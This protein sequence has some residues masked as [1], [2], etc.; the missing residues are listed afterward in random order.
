MSQPDAVSRAL[1]ADGF[2]PMRKLVVD[3]ISSPLTRAMYARALEIF[4]LVERPE[5]SAVHATHGAG[6][7]GSSR[8]QGLSAGMLA[9]FAEFE[10]DIRGSCLG[11]YRTGPKRR[12][13]RQPARRLRF[14]ST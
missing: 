7:A 8:N 12:Q 13:V 4:G 3:A 2:G 11:W 10:R 6:L 14:T 5:P 9:V 1:G